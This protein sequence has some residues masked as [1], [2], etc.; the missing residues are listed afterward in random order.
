MNE[1]LT[2]CVIDH[3]YSTVI[4]N[5]QLLWPGEILGILDGASE[6]IRITRLIDHPLNVIDLYWFNLGK[7]IVI[8]LGDDFDGS[9]GPK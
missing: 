3:I 5:L 4:E 8:K 6:R 1:M 9:L 2:R 7:R